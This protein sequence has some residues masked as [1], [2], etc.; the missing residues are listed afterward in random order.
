M[1]R[2]H[3]LA[4]AVL[5]LLGGALALFASPASGQESWS[6]YISTDMEGL[7]GVGAPGMTQ[8]NGKDYS[9]GRR[10]VTREIQRVVAGIRS[11]AAE[12]GVQS[13]RIVV[14][15]SHGDHANALIED[16]PPGV[17]YVQ[18]SLKPLGMVAE[19]DGTFD[20]VMYLGYHARA[21][22]PGF[23]AHTGSGLVLDMSINGIPAGEGEMNAAFAGAHGVPVVLI[24]GDADYVRFARE[25]YAARSEAVVTKTAVTAHAA[26]LRPVDEVQDELEAK[27]RTAMLDLDAHEPWDVG[28]AFMVEMEL[29][30]A[31]HVEVAAGLPGVEKVGPLTVRFTESD[32]ERAYRMIRILYRFLRM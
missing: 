7:S 6:V 1:I 5:A 2:R 14:N 23:L 21:G 3:P 16:F 22:Q 27:A 9:V 26:H 29:N 19:L 25:T 15:D 18:G 13:V 31:T 10:M 30:N 12:R 8:G 4:S 24:A 32:P 28:P 20:A 11:A 17:E